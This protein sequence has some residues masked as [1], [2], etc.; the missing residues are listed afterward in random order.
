MSLYGETRESLS[1]S[2]EQLSQ[3]DVLVIDLVDVGS[4]YYTY[5][6]TALL[7]ARAA[8]A[9]G[10]HVVVLDRPNPISG[11]PPRSKAARSTKASCRSSGWSRCPSATP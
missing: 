5:V 1:P 10:V 7:A 9:A 6:W 2:A 3:I 4:R 8:Q 11:D